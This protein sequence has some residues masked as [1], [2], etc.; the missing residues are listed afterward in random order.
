MT[1]RVVSE[2]EMAA[3]NRRYRGRAAATDVTAFPFA[4]D[5]LP[6][7]RRIAQAYEESE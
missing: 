4:A 5:E 7:A 2:S 1:V 6:P 3:L